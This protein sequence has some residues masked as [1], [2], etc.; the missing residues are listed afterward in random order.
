MKTKTF[1][2]FYYAKRLQKRYTSIDVTIDGADEID[3][4]LDAI[5]GGG[6]CLFQERLIAQASQQFILIAGKEQSCRNTS[7]NNHLFYF[8]RKKTIHAIRNKGKLIT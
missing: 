5:K 6:A 8:R 1:A 7:I 4:E 2:A 3:P